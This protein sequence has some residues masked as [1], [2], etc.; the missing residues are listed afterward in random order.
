MDPKAN[1]GAI[2]AA[3]R[4]TAVPKEPETEPRTVAPVVTISREAGTNAPL[5]ASKLAELLA[6]RDPERR[7][8]KRYDRELI[9]Q[10]AQ[11][12]NLPRE[13][14]ETADEHKERLVETVIHG[15]GHTG[16]P[17]AVAIKMAQ[18]IRHLAETGRA[19]IVGRGS[20][21]ILGRQTS[22]LHV[23]LQ[24]PGQ[25]RAAAY[26]AANDVD[27]EAALKAI[28]R[29]DGERRRFVKTH[30]HHDPADPALYDIV[31]NMERIS[32]DQAA[33]II[34]EA[35]TEEAPAEES[36]AE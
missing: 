25:W 20:Q 12:H 9:E 23:R 3:V 18:T 4:A 31:L 19:I 1:L 36:P 7:P 35:L 29:L 8:W 30:F 27:Q 11:E 5:V 22:I 21:V 15:L 10:V 6:R 13:L 34:A 32:A 17:S 16:S 24:A 2:S 26:A 28:H 33:R 14:V